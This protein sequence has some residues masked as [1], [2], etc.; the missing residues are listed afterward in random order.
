MVDIDASHISR[1]F[2]I[3]MIYLSCL[4]LFSSEL[5]QRLHEVSDIICSS[6]N[7]AKCQHFNIMYN[8]VDYYV[9]NLFVYNYV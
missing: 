6:C 4:R 5:Y 7:I 9:R 1:L 8:Y 2:R 3:F